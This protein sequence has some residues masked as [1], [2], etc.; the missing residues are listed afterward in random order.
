VGCYNPAPE[1]FPDTL[2]EPGPITIVKV[3]P[4]LHDTVDISC[5]G[6]DDGVIELQ[7]GGGRTRVLPN[8]FDWT[9]PDPDLVQDDSIQTSLGPGTYSVIVTDFAGCVDSAEFTLIEPSQMTM[10]ADSIY[11]LNAW[12]ITCYGDNDGYIG[13]SSDGG[14]LGHDYSWSTGAMVLADDTLQDQGGLV[15]GSYDLTIT[16]SIGCIL[17]T[18]FTLLQPNML[19]LDTIIPRY[20]GYEIACFG[21]TTGEITLIPYGGADSTL[22]TYVWSSDDGAGFEPDSM[23][24]LGVTAGTYT[25]MVTD[26]NGCDSSWVF[27]L[28][29]P[30]AIVIDTL[31]ADSAKCANTSTGAISLGVSGGIPDY[32]YL[33][34][35]TGQT[36]E[37]LSWI[38]A[39]M[40]TITV[41]DQNL[42]VKIDSVEVFEADY[43]SVDPLVTSD[44]NGTPVSCTDSSDAAISLTPLGGTE[45][46]EYLWNTGATTSDLVDIPAGTYH[47]E[48]HDYYNCID[49][50]EVVITEPDPIDYTMQIL[51]PLCYRDSTGR[52]ELLVSGGTV[53]TLDDY[54]V[55]VNGA[56]SG[57]YIESLPQ[58]TYFIRIEDLNDC[59]VETDAELIHPDSLA[60][61][62][63]T[64]NAFCRDKPDGQLYLY[65]DG[66][67]F[68]YYV[69]WDRGLPN[70]EDYFNDLYWGEYIATVTDANNCVSIDTATVEYTY[71][72]CLTIPNAFS[73][74]G[75][76]FN[77]LWII[78]GLEL[79]PGVDLKIFDRW[80]TRIYLSG[81]AADEPWDGSFNG[82]ELPIDSYH[83][84]IDLNN[85]EPPIT[86]NVTI[87]R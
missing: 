55:W 14:I 58:G 61:T 26:I 51:D 4:L 63:N 1:L 21:D 37:D 41:T 73:P 31:W 5:F 71:T 57:P 29:D 18:S 25:V 39:G 75:D 23:H 9:G 47:V 22:N 12:N 2:T 3:N 72:S 38:F 36:T 28:D 62:F 10:Q 44:Y 19:D 34:S 54:E 65:V 13:I 77:D 48:V 74:N 43:F 85:D 86:G 20:N 17:D 16:D 56:V 45:P 53:F 50:A 30:T 7:V 70:N 11:E 40:Y 78:E 83:Y 66:G 80:G 76:G 8:Q 64:E 52:I 69:S 35:P 6:M 33:W 79:Y 42:C 82:R 59:Y 67:T 27:F 46:Y 68:Q 81:N 87:V 24:Q 84:I 49:S 15:A 32:S 60:L